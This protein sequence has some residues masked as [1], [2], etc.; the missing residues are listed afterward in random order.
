MPTFGLVGGSG[1]LKT[2]LAALQGLT[3]EVVDT[4]HGRVFLRL[5]PL[6][7]GSRLVFVQRHDASP[8]RVYAQ[9]ADINYAAIALALQAKV[10]AV[11]ERSR[12]LCWDPARACAPPTRCAAP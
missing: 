6:G 1:L 11:R 12:A 3:E 10:R 4:P 2:H 5:G 8:S 7:G 9:P